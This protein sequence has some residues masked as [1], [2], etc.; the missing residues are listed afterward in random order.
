MHDDRPV[1]YPDSRIAVLDP[2]F[3]KYP[4][5]GIRGVGG[6]R[7]TD[8]GLS[9]KEYTQTANEQTLVFPLIETIEGGEAL[10]A[11]LDVPGVDGIFFGPADYS[12]S[13]G[14]VGEWEGPGV[15]E[16]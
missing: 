6:E 16:I 9:L 12:S 11:I 3:A 5:R 13:C 2:R 14:H 1:H 15:A 4:P 8:W 10:D 7:A